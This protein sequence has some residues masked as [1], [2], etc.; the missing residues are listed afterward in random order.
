MR[1]KNHILLSPLSLSTFRF[2][3]EEEAIAVANATPFG[4]AGLVLN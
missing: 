2:E 3:R 4:L 1:G